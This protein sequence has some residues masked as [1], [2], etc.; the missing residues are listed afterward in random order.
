[1]YINNVMGVFFAA[2]ILF[3]EKAAWVHK[4]HDTEQLNLFYMK[5]GVTNNEK[6]A[7]CN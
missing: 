5:I 4:A 6:Q 7:S 2:M 3:W 1:M